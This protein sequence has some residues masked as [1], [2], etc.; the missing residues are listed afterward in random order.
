MDNVNDIN[1]SVGL[2]I[3][4]AGGFEQIKIYLGKFFRMYRFQNDWI[5]VMMAILIS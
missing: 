3:R 4:H 1:E 2:K 5:M